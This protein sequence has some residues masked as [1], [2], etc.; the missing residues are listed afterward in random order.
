MK[1]RTARTTPTQTEPG[2]AVLAIYNAAA[3]SYGGGN[4]E[5]L[6]V[7]VEEVLK[8]DPAGFASEKRTAFLIGEAVRSKGE[9]IEGKA[10]VLVALAMA[11]RA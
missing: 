5:D 9:F 1:K 11:D 4:E 8:M 2:R 6:L 10:A 7:K 3:L